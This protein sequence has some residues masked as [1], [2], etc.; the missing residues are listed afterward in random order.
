MAYDERLAERVRT[1]LAAEQG[2][3]E[4]K[5][6][7]GIGFMIDGKMCAGVIGNDLIVRTGAERYE[8]LLR[9]PHVRPFDFTGRVSRGIVYVAPAGAARGPQLRRWIDIAVDAARA[10]APSKR[11]ARQPRPPRGRRS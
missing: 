3:S 10:A 5:M 11:R 4:R 8:E 6:F 2:C 7:G 1:A 9:R